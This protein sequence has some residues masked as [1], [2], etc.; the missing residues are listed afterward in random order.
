V[1]YPEKKEISGADSVF[2]D[3]EFLLKISDVNGKS[4]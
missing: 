2:I 1:K 4:E 3:R